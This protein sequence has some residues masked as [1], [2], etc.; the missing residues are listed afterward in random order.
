MAQKLFDGFLSIVAFVAILF[1][2]AS[3]FLFIFWIGLS[4]LALSN[5]GEDTRS[6]EWVGYVGVAT[7]LLMAKHSGVAI[8]LDVLRP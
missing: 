3:I 4:R 6:L 2:Y 8:N 1:N 5:G 7:L